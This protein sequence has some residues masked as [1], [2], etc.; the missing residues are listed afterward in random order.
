MAASE[1]VKI[2][3]LYLIRQMQPISLAELIL[4]V[5]ESNNVPPVLN[6]RMSMSYLAYEGQSYVEELIQAGLV[7]QVDNDPF[8]RGSKL[9]TTSILPRI[10]RLFDISLTEVIQHPEPAIRA[11]PI[12]E[13]PLPKNIKQQWP[14]IFVAMPFRDH[15]KA[16]YDDHI[17]KVAQELGITCKR[18]DE[19]TTAKSIIDEIWSA[20]YHAEL[21]IVDCTHQNP[22]VFYELGIAHTLGR[23]CILIAQTID[24]I[25]FDIRYLRTIIYAY[26]PP[27][28][29]A[30]ETLLKKTIETEM[31]L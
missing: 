2:A 23:K 8:N 15:P 17:F 19:F 20:I 24:D 25:P 6:E 12:F 22:N 1:N 11:Y 30:F 27:G 18:G 4:Y 29:Q 26:T 3:I 13:E 31:G 9:I 10:Q 5:E 14:R 28:M 7:Q 21:C 16:I